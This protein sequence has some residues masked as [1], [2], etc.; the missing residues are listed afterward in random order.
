MCEADNYLS[1]L[2]RIMNRTAIC[3]LTL[4]MSLILL[5]AYEDNFASFLYDLSFQ[6]HLALGSSQLPTEAL[7]T[8]FCL[9]VVCYIV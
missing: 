3:T 7:C 8:V 2:H 9:S 5:T 1:V 4:R 6:S